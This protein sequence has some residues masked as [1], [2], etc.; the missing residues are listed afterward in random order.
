MAKSRFFRVAVEGATTDGRVIERGWIEQMAATYKPETYGARVNMEHIKGFSPEPPF[1][2][3]GDVLALEAREVDI[4]I[5]G[6]AGK[7]LALYAQIQPNEQLLKAN[8][9]GQKIYTSI[10]VNPNFA[11][12]GK[13]YLMGLA[14]TDTPASL[15]TEVLEFAAKTPALKAV[16]DARKQQPENLFTAAL[17]T[18]FELEPEAGGEGVGAAFIAALTSVFRNAGAPAAQEASPAQPTAQSQQQV[19]Q[20]AAGGDA[21]QAAMFTAFA[22]AFGQALDAQGRAFSAQM[23]ALTE[24]VTKLSTTPNGDRERPPAAGGGAAYELTDC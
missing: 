1:N 12:T 9:A 17:E 15:G 18:A 2:A 16:F 6:K 5:G 20:P 8:K 14:V 4:E 23:T 7:K 13:A 19:A 3:Y 11:N 21:G 10:E 22:T 24:Q